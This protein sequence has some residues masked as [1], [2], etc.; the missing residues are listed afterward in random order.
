MLIHNVLA[1]KLVVNTVMVEKELDR[2][3]VVGTAMT[4]FPLVDKR[5][6]PF[7]HHLLGMYIR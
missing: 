6:L 4:K 7:S 2:D 5:A 1:F 3:I